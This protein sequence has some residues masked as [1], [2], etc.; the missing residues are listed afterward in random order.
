ME[1]ESLY[2]FR[3]I[4]ENNKQ[5]KSMDLKEKCRAINKKMRSLCI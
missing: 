4:I 2:L 3:L 5:I 1:T